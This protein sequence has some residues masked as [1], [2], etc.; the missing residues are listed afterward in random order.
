LHIAKGGSTEGC[1]T[2]NPGSRAL[3]CCRDLK[4]IE[5][6]WIGK[7]LRDVEKDLEQGGGRTEVWEKGQA[8]P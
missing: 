6:K 7:W 2:P 5:R 3:P 4:V 8:G 1:L